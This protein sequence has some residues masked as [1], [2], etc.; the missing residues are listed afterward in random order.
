MARILHA[1]L[2][3]CALT[4]LAPFSAPAQVPPTA[5]PPTVNPVGVDEHLG[6]L[7]PLDLSFQDEHQVKRTLG[8]CLDKPTILILVF[9][10]CPG[11]CGMIQSSVARAV[12]DIPLVLGKDYQILSVSFDDEEGPALALEARGNYAPLT[13]RDVPDA[14]WRFMTGDLAAITKLCDAVGFRFEKR[15]RHSYVHPNLITVVARDGKIIRYLYGTDFPPMDVGMALTEA[16]RGTPGLSIRKLVSYCFD[17]DPKNRRYAFKLFRVF[18]FTTL[19]VL[20]LFLFFLLRGKPRDRDRAA[21]SP[22]K[23][24]P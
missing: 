13:G 11:T 23:P 4:A 1:M 19:V 10:H 5:P 17:Y 16:S 8:D 21:A 12:K 14:A 24:N 22:E 2:V 7:L 9:Y 3:A 15:G 20:G 18:G 6:Q